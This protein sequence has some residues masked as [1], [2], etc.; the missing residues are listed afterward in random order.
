MLGEDNDYV[1]RD[2]IGLSNAEISDLEEK[3]VIGDL[4][5]DWAG[6]MPDYLVARL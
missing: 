3:G 4:E 5:Y 6:P 2:V 1:Y